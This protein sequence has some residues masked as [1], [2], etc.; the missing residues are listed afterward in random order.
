MTIGAGLFLETWEVISEQLPNNKREDMARK[1]VAVFA[2]HGMEKD[3]FL[4]IKGEDE[5]LDTAIDSIYTADSDE[6]GYDYDEDNVDYD[7]DE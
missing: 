2:D 3:D 1:L 4:A 6:S 5:H 7:Y